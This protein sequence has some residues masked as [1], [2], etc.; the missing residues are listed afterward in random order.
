MRIDE[1]LMS[2]ERIEIRVVY[3]GRVQG[4]GFRY[5]TNRIARRFPVSGS[6]RNLADGTVELIVAGEAGQVRTFLAA[7]LDAFD[8]NITLADEQPLDAATDV[9]EGFS[10]RR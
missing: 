2:D 8:G 9:P 7:I 5:T 1:T 6:V 4:V 10:I 3:H